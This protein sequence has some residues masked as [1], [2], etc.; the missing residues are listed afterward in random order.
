M[1]QSFIPRAALFPATERSTGAPGLVG[2]RTQWD[3]RVTIQSAQRGRP[4]G[5]VAQ[6]KIG[7]REDPQGPEGEGQEG[8]VKGR[9]HGG[10]GAKKAWHRILAEV[11]LRQSTVGGGGRAHLPWPHPNPLPAC[12]GPAKCQGE[13]VS[14]TQ[15]ARAS[16]PLG[17]PSLGLYSRKATRASRRR[18]A[19]RKQ[20]NCIKIPFPI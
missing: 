18:F 11:G 14:E 5:G 6:G 15:G 13:P 12:P 17:P 4:G 9:E 20:R 7:E 1:C 19:S 10:S 8:T 3:S 16:V 2:R